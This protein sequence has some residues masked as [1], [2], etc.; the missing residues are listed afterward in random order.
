MSFASKTILTLLPAGFLLFNGC[1]LKQMVKMAKDQQLTVTPSPLEVHGDSVAFDVSA[2]LP[3]KM[4][5][6]NKIYTVDAKYNYNGQKIDLGTVEFVSTNFPNAKTEKPVLSHHFSF[7]YKPEIGNGKLNVVGTAS[8]MTKS[9]T[10]STPGMDIADG[11]ITTS[12]LVRD[13]Y[14]VSYADHGYNNKEE[15]IP[16][17]VNFFFEQGKSVLRKSEIKGSQG[18]ML[19]AFIAKK[20]VTRTVNIVGEHSPEGTETKNSKLADDRAKVIE[21]YYKERMKFYDYKGKAD[22]ISFV[23]KGIVMDWDP[24]KKQ[25]DSVDVLTSEEKTEVLGVING[26]GSFTEKEGQLEKL[27]YYKK[28]LL[29][30]LYP[31]LRTAR[32][33]ILMVKPKKTDAEI[34]V[35]AQGIGSGSVKADTLTEQ[36]LTYAGTLT[37]SLDE[38]ESIYMAATKKTD[39]WTSHN[40]LGAVYLEKAQKQMD[41]NQK[42]KLVDMAIAQF[43]IAI[44]KNDKSAEASVN[45][46]SALLMKG[47]KPEALLQLE[48]ASALNGTDDIKKGIMGVKGAL[49]IRSAKYADAVQ[50]L[51]KAKET[52]DV[53][54]DLALANLLKK[55][56]T[57]AKSGFAAETA[58]SP[59]DAM[60]FYGAAVTAARMQDEATLTTNLKKA[61]GLDKNLAAKAISD[62]EFMNYQN[63]AAF[64]DAVT[65]K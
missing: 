60:G 37:P 22:S 25:L 23:T 63:S 17:I 43:D 29:G 11:I 51:S 39:S 58:A 53:L 24:F 7:F 35:L 32:T 41:P 44:T 61:V 21:K 36:E 3:P 8:N 4:L 45:K 50:D 64:K 33:E 10:K 42:S 47:M 6:K 57:A 1:A 5:K 12:R 13:I 52:S 46:A 56:F 19:D 59:S 38:K 28:K 9:K 14:Y 55:D 15:Y 27:P 20:N 49:E 34:L 48:K 30:K 65:V 40:N 26:S 54:F 62:L 2:T 18:K 31:K 16:V